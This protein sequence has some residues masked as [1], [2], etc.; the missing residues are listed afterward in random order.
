MKEVEG[1]EDAGC[2][3]ACADKGNLRLQSFCSL[4]FSCSLLQPFSSPPHPSRPSLRT[5]AS[6]S[7]MAAGGRKH[8]D[9]GVQFRARTLARTHA[10][11]RVHARRVAENRGYSRRRKRA[12]S[13]LVLSP[14]P[15]LLFRRR[16]RARLA[17]PLSR[18]LLLLLARLLLPFFFQQAGETGRRG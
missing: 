8:I 15:P 13:K 7:A 10:C 2:C 16:A 18:S 4:R 14:L 3:R 1:E 6:A 17:S 5:H 11:A 9:C 12:L